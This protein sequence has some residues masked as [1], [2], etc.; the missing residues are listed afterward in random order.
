MFASVAGKVTVVSVDHGQADACSTVA[1]TSTQPRATRPA[2]F[3]RQMS[4]LREN[5]SFCGSRF[6]LTS[7]APAAW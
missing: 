2:A 6:P 5:A 7:S 4:S 1:A 3:I